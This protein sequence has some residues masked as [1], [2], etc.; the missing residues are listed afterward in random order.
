[1]AAP[2]PT[3]PSLADLS[4][5]VG[6][7]TATISRVLNNRPG[8]GEATRRR[9]QEAIRKHGAPKIKPRDPARATGSRGAGQEMRSIAF[10]MGPAVKTAIDQG[11][12]F[13]SRHL[14]AIQQAAN[15]LGFLL[16]LLNG[17]DDI[18]MSGPLRSLREGRVEGVIAERLSADLLK[19]ISVRIPLVTM[20]LY[21]RVRGID[22]IIPD[23]NEA[24]REELDLLHTMGHRRIA[25]FH[26]N[27]RSGWD[28]LRLWQERMIWETFHTYGQD[29]GLYQPA[30]Y[31]E[32]MEFGEN[33]HQEAIPA[34][35]DRLF[36]GKDRP[37]ALIT[38]DFY[39]LSIREECRA[40]G[41][42]IP[43]DLSLVG[44]DDNLPRELQAI[45]PLTTYRQNFEE[46]G[47]EAVRA[48]ADRIGHPH[49]QLAP[50][51]IAVNGTLLVRETAAP[52][53]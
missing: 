21:S 36:R 1:M 51:C 6:V 27:V 11:S 20:N 38:N 49:P 46:M 30:S 34:F 7:S 15:E 37:T 18:A 35:F 14:L 19:A 4:A 42:R 23:I 33:G 47:R 31:F 40:R 17:E 29:L 26:A 53:R 5:I 8:I 41:L 48:L 3:T 25:C 16:V 32:K 13:Y 12:S 10:V 39:A 43:E 52:L 50:R 28:R 2:E 9:V 22:S 24:I 44:F 45:F